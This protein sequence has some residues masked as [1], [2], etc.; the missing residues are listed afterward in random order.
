[1]LPE[2]DKNAAFLWAITGLG[3]ALPILLAIYAAVRE[4]LAKRRLERMREAN[5]LRK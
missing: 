5:T 4:R 2:F 1:M 3:L